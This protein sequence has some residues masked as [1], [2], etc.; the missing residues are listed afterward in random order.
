MYRVNIYIYIYK[1]DT[2]K[3]IFGTNLI[4]LKPLY[5]QSFKHIL[6]KLNRCAALHSN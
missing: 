6:S 5:V 4:I 3:N 2:S 1:V